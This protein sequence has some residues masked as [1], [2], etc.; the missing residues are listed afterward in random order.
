MGLFTDIEHLPLFKN[1]VITIGSFDGVHAGHKKILQQVVT[2]ADKINGTPMLITFYPHP[3]EVLKNRSTP[4]EL[5]NTREEKYAIIFAAGIKH[6]IE[7]PF[8]ERF[9]KLSATDYIEEFLVKGFQPHTIITGYDHKFGNNREG[10]FELL[11]ALSE[12][13]SYSV[14][15]I[16]AQMIHDAAIS[17]TRIRKALKEG[18]VQTAKDYLGYS[19]SF[20]GE[21]IRGKQLGRTLG[22]PTANLQLDD[23]KKLVP[24]NGVYA[25]RVAY[26]Q[27]QLNAVMNIGIRPTVDGSNR[28]IEIHVFDFNEDIYGKVLKVTLEKYLRNEKKF[29]NLEALKTQI[30]RD[31]EAARI[32]LEQ[33]SPS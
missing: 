4:L 29:E 18:D 25:V 5:L 10:D 31:K 8:N 7:V 6:I 17:S 26:G 30:A 22:F 20:K 32:F 3:S 28:V 15:E 24:A 12:K 14:L 19:Y 27:L 16:P 33:L 21:V 13:H 2:Q 11:R 9:S 23:E 1:A